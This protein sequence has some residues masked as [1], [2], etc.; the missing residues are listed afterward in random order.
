MR[1]P[2]LLA[3][4]TL[5]LPGYAG[6]IQLHWS[7]GSSSLSF[8]TTA[9]C[10][11]IIE[12]DAGEAGLPP[13]WRLLWVAR[14]CATLTPVPD[15]D[16]AHAEIGEIT[17]N[18]APNA[19]ERKGHTQVSKFRSPLGEVTRTARICFD[20]PGQSSGK[21]QVVA[22]GAGADLEDRV[23][24]KSNVVTFNGGVEASLPSAILGAVGA[25][26][27]ATFTITSKGVGLANVSALALTAADTA[28][29]IPFEVGATTDTSFVATANVPVRISGGYLQPTD[30]VG[31][32]TSAP[33][34]TATESFD[35]QI[36]GNSW[37][38]VPED[39]AK[40]TAKDFAFV[41]TSI[42]PGQPGPW[43]DLFH[44]FYI[45]RNVTVPGGQEKSFGH[46]WSRDLQTW[47]LDTLAF[48]TGAAGYDKLHIWA[49]S[50]VQ[51]G[52]HYYM[53]YAGVDSVE[54]QRI[55]R[56]YTSLLD[57]TN[58]DW[59][60]GGRKLVYDAT[61]TPW[62]ENNPP[63]FGGQTQFRD[64]FV[65]ADP[66]SVGRYL[67][68]Y[69]ALDDT[70]NALAAGL[71]RNVPGTMDS[72]INRGRY[73]A[74]QKANTG[75]AQLESPHVF[76]DSIS[77][78]R[79]MFTAGESGT[80]F[81]HSSLR[82]LQSSFGVADTAAGAW[83]DDP[84]VLYDYLA[85]DTTVSGWVASEQL[86]VGRV[87]FL[88]GVNVYNYDG[89]H[90]SRMYWSGDDF[91]LRVPSVASVD[92]AGAKTRSV[93][94]STID[95]SPGA[96][97]LNFR[98]DLPVKMPVKLVVYDVMGR[99]VQ[100]LVNKPLRAGETIVRWDRET[101]AGMTAA[102]GVYYACLTYATGTRTLQLPIVR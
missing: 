28:W 95:F 14:G 16:A 66:D 62:V 47:S 33:L 101:R 75:I 31:G 22:L 30:E 35:L 85:P 89:I 49:P 61:Q 102:S 76:A 83:S 81:R 45:R 58:T 29:S 12:A 24:Q 92:H 25:Q 20:L 68:V 100:V 6:A 10:T 99:I 98:I 15:P 71:A 72:W 48:Q 51:S 43:H 19:A 57:T 3:V 36:K 77:G 1:L 11:L 59:T 70:L 96:R 34:A 50:I 97:Q 9:R 21:L 91:T 90:I 82:M 40:Y 18:P 53:Y 8:S 46:L 41:Y 74:T 86:R 73:G 37:L 2:Y 39:P 55:M 13:E 27:T 54:D 69:T 32:G 65:F 94:L 78:W 63:A 26:P 23:I 80:A 88:A 4:G 67:M 5:L 17:E 56:V 38:I 93:R 44:I 7:T 60:A 42:P 87:D 52:P 84:I 79:I 64:P